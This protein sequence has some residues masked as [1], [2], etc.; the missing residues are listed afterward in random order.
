MKSGKVGFSILTLA[1]TMLCLPTLVFAGEGDRLERSYD[2]GRGGSVILQNVTG[3]ISV[4]GW[5]KDRVEMT[6]KHAGGPKK[7]LN[8]VVLITQTN[9]NLIIT[10]SGEKSF[11]LFGSS[12][13]SVSYRLLVPGSSHLKVETVSGDAKI[14]DFTGTLEVKTVSGD[15]RI[16]DTK[17]RVKCKTIS[18]D[19][20]LKHIVGD[21]ELITTSGDLTVQDLKGSFDA[22]SVSGDMALKKMIGNLDIKTTSGE[23]V[24]RDLKGS[25][26]AESVSGDM[27]VDSFSEAEKIEIETVSGDVSMAGILAPNV[28]Y[29]VSSHSGDINFKI[30]KGSDFELQTRTS[31][32]HMACDFELKAYGNI[33]RGQLQGIVGKGGASL[34][35]STFN[36]DIRVNRR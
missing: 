10:T 33:D 19:I 30:P 12:R 34:S 17:S 9:G 7:D 15:I 21:T 11:N 32:G 24:V 18:G 35:I 28:S 14:Q 20:H 4:K 27:D 6:A 13:T 16:L 22:E 5:G 1:L 3:D 31:T 25:Y 2:L 8:E 29:T 36:G 26:E 23:I